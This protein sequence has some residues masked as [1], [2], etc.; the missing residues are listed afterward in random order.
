[1]K[2]VRMLAAGAVVLFASAFL[3]APVRA[4]D[5]RFIKKCEAEAEAAFVPEPQAA[6]PVARRK[7][8]RVRAAAAAEKPEVRRMRAPRFTVRTRPVPAPAAPAPTLASDEERAVTLES[9]MSRR[10]RGFIDPQPM[11]V[12]SFEAL[13]RPRLEAEHLAP[14]PALPANDM[15]AAAPPPDEVSAAAE[16]PPIVVTTKV[17]PTA[18]PA[19]E[20]AQP[21]AEPPQRVAEAAPVAMPAP[22][23]AETAQPPGNDRPS[24]FPLHQLV[25]T[26]CGALGVAS[27]LRFIVR[28]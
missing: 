12:N 5:D 6:A 10:F 1:M 4:C 27:A 25:L 19:A 14:A 16:A 24:G 13:R 22:V 17:A 28:A 9:P 18:Q 20:A 11:T 8:S 23:P 15:T 26:L 7:N 21:V 2:S 3:T